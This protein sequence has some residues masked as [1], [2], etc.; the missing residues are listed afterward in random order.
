[1]KTVCQKDNCVGCMAC[2]EVCPKSAIKI[3][4]E[5]TSLNAVIDKTKCLNCNLCHHICQNN[6]MV[7]LVRPI[8]WKQGWA[9]DNT[10]RANSSS[11]GV[12]QAIE[13]AFIR[14]GGIVCSCTFEG[15]VFRFL[16]AETETDVKKFCGSKYVKSTPYGIYKK[17]LNQLKSGRR[18]LFVG[19]PCQVAALKK[20]AGNNW[21]E[22]LYTIDLICHGTPSQKLLNL[23]LEQ[24]NIDVSKIK[25]IRFRIKTNIPFE[26]SDSYIGSPGLLDKYSIAFLN[27]ICYTENCYK[28]QYARLER[29]SDI[30]LGDSWGSALSKEEQNK[31]ISLILSQT[32]KGN[33]LVDMAELVLV[34]V[35]LMNAVK[36]NHQL[37]EATSRPTGRVDFFKKIKDGENFDSIIKRLYYK[38]CMKQFVKKILI[39]LNICKGGNYGI[40]V[41]KK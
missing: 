20:Y 33:K 30:T 37:K 27:G 31:G 22:N 7:N 11:G 12:A 9:K 34:D 19:L 26:A 3:V 16:F 5:L 41:T 14:Y 17:I 25:N 24:H 2:I 32:A 18:I 1:M 35:D 6:D 21:N 36:H 8:E 28:C 40:V 15:G 13:L 38:Q 4:E 39:A 10:I 29:V 23:F